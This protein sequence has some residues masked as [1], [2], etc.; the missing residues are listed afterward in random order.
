M[1][2]K[3]TETLRTDVPISSKAFAPYFEPPYHPGLAGVAKLFGVSAKLERELVALR[4]VAE[5]LAVKI[6]PFAQF[7]CDPRFSCGGCHNCQAADA[8]MEYEA[9]KKGEH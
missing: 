7:E 1:S 8:L 2:E 9:F 3:H 6:A 5:G 4:A